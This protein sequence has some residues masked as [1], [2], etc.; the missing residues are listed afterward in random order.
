MTTLPE[1]VLGIC[2]LFKLKHRINLLA[3]CNQIIEELSKHVG[4]TQEGPEEE[5]EEE[6]EESNNPQHQEEDAFL[7]QLFN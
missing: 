5:F 4:Q 6:P 1:R 2:F 3:N 7:N